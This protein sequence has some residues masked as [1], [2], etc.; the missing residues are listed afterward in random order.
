MDA[1]CA[2]CLARGSGRCLTG[3]SMTTGARRSRA[4]GSS[5]SRSIGVF[6]PHTDCAEGLGELDEVRVVEVRLVS[7]AKNFVQLAGYV[8]VGVVSEN[9][10]DDID[11]VLDRR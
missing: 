2:C 5:L 3:T 9:Y 1:R 6:C 7:S 11:P 10:G 4:R 8:A